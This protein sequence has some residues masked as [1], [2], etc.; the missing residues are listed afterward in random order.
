[1]IPIFALIGNDDFWSCDPD[2]RPKMSPKNGNFEFSWISRR[3]RIGFPKL[4]GPA[5]ALLCHGKCFQFSSPNLQWLASFVFRKLYSY[6]S[7][8]WPRLKLRTRTDNLFVDHVTSCILQRPTYHACLMYHAACNVEF[9]PFSWSYSH[10]TFSNF[11]S[12]VF[13]KVRF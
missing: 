10:L 4:F 3:D 9:Q 5:Y 12:R 11:N 6:P 1:M 2:F 8:S 7:F 13:A